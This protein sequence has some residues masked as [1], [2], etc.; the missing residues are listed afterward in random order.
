MTYSDQQILRSTLCIFK[1]SVTGRFICLCCF[2]YT[3]SAATHFCLCYFKGICTAGVFSHAVCPSISNNKNEINR[4]RIHISWSTPPNNNQTTNSDPTDLLPSHIICIHILKS[5][6]GVTW[7]S[8][9][10][11]F[12]PSDLI[13]QIHQSHNWQGPFHHLWDVYVELVNI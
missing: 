9:H 7:T 10:I 11:A 13:T 1:I 4:T 3:K 5:A 2:F 6:Q 12:E 8:T